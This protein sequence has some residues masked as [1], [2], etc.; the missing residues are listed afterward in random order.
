MYIFIIEEITHYFG[1]S[2]LSRILRSVILLRIEHQTG[3]I[4]RFVLQKP[5]DV[6]LNADSRLDNWCRFLCCDDL[7][8]CRDK[9]R[10]PFLMLGDFGILNIDFF[11]LNNVSNLRMAASKIEANFFVLFFHP[12]IDTKH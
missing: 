8:C 6:S 9:F 4:R 7:G 3:F 12:F 5:S 2:F 11:L 1:N 10:Q